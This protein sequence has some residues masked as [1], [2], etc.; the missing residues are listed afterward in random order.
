MALSA[1]CREILDIIP[2]NKDTHLVILSHILPGVN[3]KEKVRNIIFAIF[4]KSDGGRADNLS[5]CT[6][7]PTWI[8]CIFY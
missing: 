6:G 1:P 8:M 2:S 3:V 4:D 5:I 7:D